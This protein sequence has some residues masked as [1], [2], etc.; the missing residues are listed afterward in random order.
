MPISSLSKISTLERPRDAVLPVEAGGRN[1]LLGSLPQDEFSQLAPHFKE[2]LLERGKVLQEPGQAVG[3]VYFPHGGMISVLVVMPEGETVETM[4]IG[5]EGGVGLA[6]GIGS[7]AALNRVIVQLPGRATQVPAVRW[8]A[9]AQQSQAV[10]DLIVC[11]NDVQLAQ[12]QQSVACNALHDVEARLCRW[13]LEARDRVGSDTLPLT[14]EFLAEMLGVR[15][16]TVTI[17]ARM[18]QSAGFVHY[19]RGVVH[20]RDVA[21]LEGAA[22]ECYRVVRGLTE[23]FRASGS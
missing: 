6:S 7:Q 22:C 5:R 18:L 21:A 9:L 10:R 14:Q 11:Y 4:T 20:L 1:R 13:L 17:V 2:V 15:R 23:R 8:A 12:V 16:T 19:R 3:S